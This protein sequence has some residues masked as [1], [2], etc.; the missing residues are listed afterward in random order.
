MGNIIGSPSYGGNGGKAFSLRCDNPNLLWRVPI[1]YDSKHVVG[2]GAGCKRYS[3][4]LI[5]KTGGTSGSSTTRVGPFTGIKIN[6]SDYV[7]ALQLHNA[8]GSYTDKY[9]KNVTL[10]KS[11]DCPTGYA[12][13]GLSGSSGDWID[14]VT[15]YCSP[16][17]EYC[18]TSDGL[19][20]PRCACQWPK[21]QYNSNLYEAG[22]PFIDSRCIN[23]SNSNTGY[24]IADDYKW[25]PTSNDIQY[26]N[27]GILYTKIANGEN[28][29]NLDLNSLDKVC[30]RYLENEQKRLE[31]LSKQAEEQAKLA[32]EQAKQAEAAAKL[33]EQQQ[34]AAEEQE[35][36]KQ[37]AADA[38][39]EQARLKQEADEAAAEANR[40]QDQIKKIEAEE[41]KQK[42]Y[43]IIAIIVSISVILFISII[44]I[45]IL[46]K[47]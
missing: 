7:N 28:I 5:G 4:D 24:S 43:V 41:Q 15:F 38:A 21:S 17:G 16:Y 34:Q 14:H 2:L 36:L 11:Y 42:M 26:Q 46:S 23:L 44:G 20:D 45:I 8:D 29:T 22:G 30:K 13:S 37:E 27:C 31:E 18:K 19:K 33:A 9:G 32:E 25:K 47:V 3:E 12:L 6:A 39:A 1:V 10:D 35:R 40:I